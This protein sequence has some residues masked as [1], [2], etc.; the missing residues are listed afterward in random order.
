F[1]LA[2]V[3]ARPGDLLVN[4]CIRLG[5]VTGAVWLAY[6]MTAGLEIRE[7]GV[8]H[9]FQFNTWE[10]VESYDWEF[11]WGV[12]GLRLTLR[13]T[14]ASLYQPVPKAMKE[15]VDRAL[16]GRVPLVTQA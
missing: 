2:W 5:Y 1:E 16:E 14:V 9:V 4:V 15:V 6:L 7:R 13:N 8:V 11:W 10:E 3:G 12:L